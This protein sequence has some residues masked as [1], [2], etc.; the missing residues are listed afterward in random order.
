MKLSE[1]DYIRKGLVDLCDSLK[2][3]ISSEN[4]HSLDIAMLVNDAIKDMKSAV[5]VLFELP[6]VYP[7]KKFKR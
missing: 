3:R 4:T 6:P 1:Q 2:H 7:S 5:N